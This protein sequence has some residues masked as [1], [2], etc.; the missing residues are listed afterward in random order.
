MGLTIEANS[1]SS[2]AKLV[3]YEDT[4]YK[5][6]GRAKLLVGKKA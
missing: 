2:T 5:N 3:K 1:L 6:H 4:G